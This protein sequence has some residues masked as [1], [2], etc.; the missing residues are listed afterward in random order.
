M[1]PDPTPCPGR[2][3][4]VVEDDVDQLPSGHL[5]DVKE[6]NELLTSIAS[7]GASSPCRTLAG[8]TPPGLPCSGRSTSLWRCCWRYWRSATPSWLCTIISEATGCWRGCG[9][10]D[11]NGWKRT[12]NAWPPEQRTGT[13]AEVAQLARPLEAPARRLRDL[14]EVFEA[15][16]ILAMIRLM[17]HRLG[18]SSRKRLPVA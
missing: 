4:V 15:M 12:A 11:R 13:A 5:D 6:T 10:A 2:L 9:V 17:L 14:P 18:H 16:I 8:L 7:A 1:P 3:S